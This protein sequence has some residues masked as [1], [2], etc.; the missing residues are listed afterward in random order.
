MKSRWIG[1]VSIII[2]I[3]SITLI[4]YPFWKR[5]SYESF[6]NKVT[7]RVEFEG[8]RWTKEEFNTFTKNM[9]NT[10]ATLESLQDKMFIILDD[11]KRIMSKLE[12]TAY[13]QK[14][15]LNNI[16]KDL[17]EEDHKRMVE[18]SGLSN[19]PVKDFY[20]PLYSA[21]SDGSTPITVRSEHDFRRSLP[22]ISISPLGALDQEDQLTW[23][24][25]ENTKER[26]DKEEEFYKKIPVYLPPFLSS[27]N[28]VL[29]NAEILRNNAGEASWG[30]RPRVE[31]MKERISALANKIKEGFENKKES[32]PK[33][34]KIRTI[35]TVPYEYWG[36]IAEEIHTKVTRI[37]KLINGSIEDVRVS[38]NTLEELGK[39]GKQNAQNAQNAL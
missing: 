10:K 27:V 18:S 23:I 35:Q 4:V 22:R 11:Y 32:C 24:N 19:T 20:R 15:G 38:E 7:P 3:I 26:Y 2:P 1:W 29:T 33:S 34:I 17:N 5:K 39:K 8:K 30:M 14:E 9:K 37:Q 25:R 31:D 12:N 28:E 21:K 13:K 6:K 16:P 36:K